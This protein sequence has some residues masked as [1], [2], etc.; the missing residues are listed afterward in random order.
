MLVAAIT[1]AGAAIV[2]MTAGSFFLAEEHSSVFNRI[3][4][5]I[6]SRV[7]DAGATVTQFAIGFIMIA[8]A[9]A[10]V[11]QQWGISALDRCPGPDDHHRPGGLVGRG[12]RLNDHRRGNAPNR[13]GDLHRLRVGAAE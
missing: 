12:S 6:I 11:E 5:P 9:G 1:T 3:S 13:R 2:A 8:G 4:H 10:V 7:M